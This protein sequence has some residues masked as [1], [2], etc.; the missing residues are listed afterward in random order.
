MRDLI[1]EYEG[2]FSRHSL[3][4]GEVKDFVHRIHVVDERPCHLPCRRVPPSQYQ[5]LHVALNEM[6]ERG[7]ICKLVSE[8]ASPL[9]LCWK[10]NG[11]LSIC[12]DFRWLNARTVKDA[13]PLPQRLVTIHS[14][15]LW[16]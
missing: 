7:I 2:I 16:I 5:K 1:L 15:A 3:D 10:K 6:E 8:F 4:C 9:V 12:T 13:Q 11:D 14:L